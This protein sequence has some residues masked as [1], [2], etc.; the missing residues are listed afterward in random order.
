MLFFNSPQLLSSSDIYEM[1]SRMQQPFFS[2]Y[3]YY[4]CK[5]AA[6]MLIK[7]THDWEVAEGFIADGAICPEVYEKQAIKITCFLAE[8]YGYDECGMTDIEGQPTHDILGV[9]VPKRWTA[10]RL[11]ALLW[12]IFESFARG[13]KLQREEFP[14]FM[15]ITEENTRMLQGALLRVAWVNVKKASRH[16]DG[17]G[18]DATRLDAEEVKS[19]VIRNR[20]VLQIQL[21]SL[22]P[23]LIIACGEPVFNGLFENGLFGSGI[24]T[25][26]KW[27]IQTDSSGK[28]VLETSHPGYHDEWSYE[29]IF[30]LHGL[31]FDELFSPMNS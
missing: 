23:D 9:G 14:N 17:R 31:I 18:G 4:G 22:V 24:V 3:N 21:D 5:E 15:T 20:K 16:D 27:I 12:L 8:S 13:R 10:K 11:P 2:V 25:G 7:Q 26:R 1:A 28:Q 6:I 19:A 29:G 30:N